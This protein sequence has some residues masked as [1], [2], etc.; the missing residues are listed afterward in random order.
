MELGDVFFS[1]VNYARMSGINPDSAL[2][3][4]NS[5][6]INRFQKMENLALDKNLKLENL[7]LEQMD[8]LWEEAKKGE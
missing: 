8:L 1:L 2:E 3:R 6:F 7:S 4:T 5:K